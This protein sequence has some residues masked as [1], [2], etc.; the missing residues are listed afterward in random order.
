MKK[1]MLINPFPATFACL[2][3]LASASN[4]QPA[5]LII[6]RTVDLR[7]GEAQ[8]VSLS[9][10]RAVQV[11]LLDLQERRDEVNDAVRQ[12]EVRVEVAGQVTNLTSG[13]YHLPVTLGSVQIDCPIT[14]GY[15]EKGGGQNPCEGTGGQCMWK[16][17]WHVGD[18]NRFIVGAQISGQKTAYTAWFWADGG[19]KKLAGFRT[20]PAGLPLSGY[21]SFIE[22]F[23]R[24]GKSVHELRRAR[25]GNGWVKSIEGDWVPLTKA[26]F[27]ASGAEWESKD[28]IN[29]GL[30]DGSFF[31]ATGGNISR[32]R[33]LKSVINLPATPSNPP[34]LPLSLLSGAAE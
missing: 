1:Q 22:D 8:L 9:D 29:A 5:P 14:K 20:R 32:T 25:F 6:H 12:A 7:I 33:E 30:E 15:L 27:T 4:G 10:G 13:T 24:D 2:L 21:Y 11:K 34:N 17:N 3:V 16:Y 31:L 23:R 28:H 18:T 26:R 19:W